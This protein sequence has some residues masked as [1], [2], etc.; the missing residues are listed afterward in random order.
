MRFCANVIFLPKVFSNDVGTD[1]ALARIM[2]TLCWGFF[3]NFGQKFCIG[4]G[5]LF[6]WKHTNSG[7]NFFN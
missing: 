1:I 2:P 6:A 7:Q 3:K 5:T 4:I